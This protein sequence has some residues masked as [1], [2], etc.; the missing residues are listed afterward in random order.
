MWF[1]Y[2]RFFVRWRCICLL[3]FFFLLYYSIRAT[4]CINVIGFR[5]WYVQFVPSSFC[6]DYGAW[7]RSHFSEGRKPCLVSF[8]GTISSIGKF[9]LWFQSVKWWFQ[10]NREYFH[11]GSSAKSSYKTTER[12]P[13]TDGS[14]GR[15]ERSLFTK[16][17][18]IIGKIESTKMK[19]RWL[20]NLYTSKANN[21]KLMCKLVMS[22]FAKY[23]MFLNKKS[24]IRKCWQVR[25]CSNSY[26]ATI[27]KCQS[28]HLLFNFTHCWLCN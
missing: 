15:S 16:K 4:N 26:S 24:H 19:W 2:F 20:M 21:N 12:F 18:T 25:N 14:A 10:S 11:G 5:F 13:E 7:K 23:E 28:D 22:W 3:T 1:I 17:R 8:F 9:E 27:D 6:F